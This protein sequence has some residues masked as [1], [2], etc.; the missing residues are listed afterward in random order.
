MIQCFV[1]KKEFQ[2]IIKTFYQNNKRNFPWR[3]TTN[4]YFIFL[5]EICLQQTQTTRVVTK[6]QEII[7]TFPTVESLADAPFS[8][9]LRVWSGLGYNRRAKFLHDAAQKIVKEYNGIF[10]NT[11][12]L[13]DA[14]PGVGI[15][16]ASAIVVYAFNTPAVFIETNIRRIFIHHFF[17][18]TDDISDKEILPLVEKTMDTKNPREWYWALMDYGS[19]LPKIVTNPNR[20]SIHYQKQSRF[21]GSV[22]EVRGS[23]LK[24]LLISSPQKEDELKKNITGDKD[25][26]S[27]ALTQL[28]NE[29]FVSRIDDTITLQ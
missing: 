23:I 2:T 12:A 17:N 11:V 9:V 25:H 26:F 6:Y 21:T 5:S 19:Y 16:T 3:E 4:P 13:L 14:L 15:N 20:R 24:T 22:R 28:I 27:E 18:D 10:P 1:N 29:K 8:E 7:Q